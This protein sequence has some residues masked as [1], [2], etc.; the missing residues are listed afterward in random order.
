MYVR[1]LEVR[2]RADR[3]PPS[4]QSI[5]PI[6]KTDNLFDPLYAH[7]EHAVAFGERLGIVPTTG[8]EWPSIGTQN[9]RHFRVGNAGWSAVAINNPAAQP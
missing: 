3:L 6:V 2:R 8:G 1:S 4:E 7:I 5:A 9:R